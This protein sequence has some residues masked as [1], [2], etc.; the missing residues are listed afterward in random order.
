MTDWINRIRIITAP[1]TAKPRFEIE[2]VT[3]PTTAPFKFR[4]FSF[5]EANM[6]TIYD[7]LKSHYEK[8]L[9]G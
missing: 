4:R 6:R 9:E 5:D 1:T 2:I 8:E 7:L 3:D